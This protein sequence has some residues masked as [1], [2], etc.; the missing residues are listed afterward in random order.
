MIEIYNMIDKKINS[1]LNIK[2][3]FLKQLNGYKCIK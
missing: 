2:I 3:N 1:S